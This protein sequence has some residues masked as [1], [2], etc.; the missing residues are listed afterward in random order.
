[1]LRNGMVI[2]LFGMIVAAC[3][4][5]STQGVVRGRAASSG[6]FGLM[7]TDDITVDSAS[8]F[9]GQGRVMVGSFLVGFSTYDTASYSSRVIRTGNAARNTLV[10]VDTAVMQRVVDEAYASLVASLKAQ[11]YT[12]VDRAELVAAPGFAATKSYPNPYEDSSGSLFGTSSRVSYLSPTGFGETKIF[13]GD[14]SGTMGGFASENALVAAANYAKASGTRVIHAVYVLGF[15][16]ATPGMKL[17]TMVEIGQGVTAKPAVTKLGMLANTGGFSAGNGVLSLGQPI[18]SDH[19]FATITNT[20][21][22]GA[23]AAE[24]AVNVL[25]SM[26]G[27]GGSVARDFSFTARPADYAAAATDALAQVNAGFVA[28]MV[29]LR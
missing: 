19:E 5:T 22:G 23:I 9:K 14:I 15:V 20:T 2:A 16:N 11:G 6:P 7:R 1:M 28:K 17:T 21:T 24:T 18:T 10:G 12:V 4:P 25:S 3:T 13:Q 29:S 8:A 27:V 26:A